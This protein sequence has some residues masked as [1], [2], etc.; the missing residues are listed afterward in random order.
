MDEE[1]WKKIFSKNLRFLIINR[2]F[3][4]EDVARYTGLSKAIICK[5]VTGKS[6]PS[7]YNA[8]RLCDVL[9]LNLEDIACLDDYYFDLSKE[10]I[11]LHL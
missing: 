8:I 1:R 4:C 11:Y 5:Y 2:G 10:N 3:T 6:I 9:G 7:L